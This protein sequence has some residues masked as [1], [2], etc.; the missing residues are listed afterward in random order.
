MRLIYERCTPA[1]GVGG[2]EHDEGGLEI[3]VA[4][5][6]WIEAVTRDYI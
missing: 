3:K 5:W 4:A 1:L 6:E 2:A